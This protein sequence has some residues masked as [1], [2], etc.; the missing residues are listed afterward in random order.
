MWPWRRAARRALERSGRRALERSRRAAT[1]RAAAPRAAARGNLTVTLPI[2]YANAGPHIGHLFTALLGDA[3]ARWARVRGGAAR[4][5]TGTDEH[6]AKVQEAADAAGVPP[7]QF[8]D[9]VSGEFRDALA[10]FGV[11]PDDWV[12]TSER[13]HA[14]AVSAL[15]ERLRD[16]GHIYLGEHSGWYCRAD[17]AFVPENAVD[18][19]RRLTRDGGRPVE[20]V[21]ETNYKFRL[22]AF[23]D[24]LLG[25]LEPGGGRA[26]PVWPPNRA[27]EA[28]AMVRDAAGLHD[29]SVSRLRSRVPWSVP[30]PGDA[31]HGVY[32]WLDALA[33]YLTTAGYPDASPAQMA[34]D[35]AWPA[36]RQII[37]KDILR[38]HAVLWP[39]F[40]MGAGLPP[41]A[42]L[43]VHA[44]WTV[45]HRKMSKSLGNVTAPAELLARYGVD[46]VRYFML[47]DGA[48]ADDCSFSHAELALRAN[49]DLADT[50]G[51]LVGRATAPSILGGA[52]VPRPG[53]LRT[54]ADEEFVALLR[55]LPA[56]VA[57]RFDAAD[58]REGLREVAAALGAANGYFAAHEPWVLRK[59][60]AED[61]AADERLR[62][63]V[64]HTLEALRIAGILLQP[65]V[66][67]SADALLH[68]LGVGPGER[69]FDRCELGA[70][71]GGEPLGGGFPDGWGKVLFQ[72]VG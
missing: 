17:E 53:A 68:R 57:R 37:G 64:Y 33:N 31:E 69:G 1:T 5:T 59:T 42:G 54:A 15:W 26:S 66:P 14:R 30:V 10:A 51:N 11:R 23:R 4:L 56:R 9:A 2:F 44:H 43:L 65:A 7:R 34:A 29:V 25:W 71:A 47:R 58:F 39:A 63:V 28:A 72:K 55:A 13:R 38:F 18:S 21:S 27:R 67:G 40:L 46:P 22:G 19:A 62:T 45:E 24:R 20:W 52:A 35:G 61:P 70:R 49:H 16:G 32:V 6:G 3:S 41:P 36:A 50:L 60:R 12:R 48:L 8:C